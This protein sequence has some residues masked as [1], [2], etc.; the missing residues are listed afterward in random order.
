M[1]SVISGGNSD[2]GSNAGSFYLN[3]NWNASNANV[4]VGANLI[5][6]QHIE[7]THIHPPLKLKGIYT[8]IVL[9]D[10]KS[11]AREVVQN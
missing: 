7:I 11:N 6:S 4:N 5:F 10:S 3:S 9:V 8:K 2:N 1:S